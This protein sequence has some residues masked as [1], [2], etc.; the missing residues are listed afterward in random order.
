MVHLAVI[1]A[2]WSPQNHTLAYGENINF[3]KSFV[4]QA[5]EEVHA[6]GMI[7]SKDTV[8]S[9]DIYPAKINTQDLSPESGAKEITPLIPST[10]TKTSPSTLNTTPQPMQPEGI[11]TPQNSL[12]K[13]TKS[14]HTTNNPNSISHKTDDAQ[15]SITP[16]TAHA[17]VLNN[18]PPPYPRQSRRLGE[19]GKV[20]LAAEIATNGKALQALVSTSS[21]YP[22]LD[23]AALESV[24]KWQFIPG[25][26]AGVPQKMW[27][28]IP[29]N[30]ILE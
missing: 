29:I 22:R 6:E 5:K 13:K 16:P 15:T 2:V 3:F 14:S 7:H 27:V 24:K 10:S 1:Q 19:Q 8:Q 11:N 21:G 30:F 4:V 23:R 9:K 17:N 25:K 12:A 18:P 20:V 28:S 26:R